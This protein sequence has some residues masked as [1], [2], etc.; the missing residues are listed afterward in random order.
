[1]SDG[2]LVVG[3]DVDGERVDVRCAGGVVAAVGADVT[4][5]PGETVVRGA[6]AAIPGLHDHHLHLMAMAARRRTRSDVGA[7]RVSDGE[8]LARVLAGGRCGLGRRGWLRAVGYHERDLG[9]LDRWTWTGS[10]G[11]DRL[12]VQHRSGHLWVLNS[13]GCRAVGLDVGDVDGPPW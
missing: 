12:R 7:E 4:P 6:A 1:M 11:A 5:R 9:R 2:L 3:V 13:A 10:S 8:G